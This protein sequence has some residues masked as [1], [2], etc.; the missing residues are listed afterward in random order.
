VATPTTTEARREANQWLRAQ[1]APGR[2][3]FRVAAVGLSV[4]TFAH[5]TQWAAL[6]VLVQSAF[7][8]RTAEVLPL[9]LLVMAAAAAV[10]VCVRRWADGAGERG[11]A[12][13]LEALRARLLDRILPLDARTRPADPAG[14]THALLELAQDVAGYHG[15]V[16]PLHRSTVASMGIVL[17]AVAVVHW[18]VALLLVAATA[19]MPVNMRLAGL[20]AADE[21]RRQLRAMQRLS[22]V[23]LDNFRGMR[24]IRSLGATSRQAQ[25]LERSSDALNRET[26]RVLRKAFLSGLVMDAV[27]T[28]AIAVCASYVGFALLGYVHVPGTAPLTLG[29]GLFVLVLCPMYFL[30]IRRVSAGYH[31]RDRAL[32]A[33]EVLEPIDGATAGAAP[34]EDAA[35]GTAPVGAVEV[36]LRDVSYQFPGADAPLLQGVDLHVP[37]G[38]WTAITGRSGAGKTTILSVVAGLAQA[39][40]GDVSWLG[41]MPG[42]TTVP[43][44]ER[45]SWIGQDTVV[46]EGTVAQN[47]RFGNP[48]ASDAAVHGAAA[49]AGLAEVIGRLPDGLD[50]RIGDGGWGLSAGEARRLAIARAALRG[51]GLWILDEPTA[52]LDP[53]TEAAVLASLRSATAGRT[54]VVATHSAA[55]V[56]AADTHVHLDEAGLHVVLPAA[57]E[58]GA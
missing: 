24:T 26:A 57:S 27:V 45:A 52:H 49:L 4:A 38:A 5:V 43:R 56:A 21:S 44:V 53:D 50:T 16:G 48:D 31:D 11:R 19:L 1:S 54:V 32:A 23:V 28:F 18:P 13:V 35:V 33:T 7:E 36:L 51:S 12:A 47:I 58:V 20:V 41:P 39:T 3:A 6:A 34:A 17:A 30:P 42:T 8:G 10:A 37:A 25:V 22:A 2:G 55:I 14:D 9:A 29:A 15:T 46:L 40:S